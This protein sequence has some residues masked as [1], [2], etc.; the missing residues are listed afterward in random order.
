[1]TTFRPGNPRTIRFALPLAFFVSYLFASIDFL[2]I[3]SYLLTTIPLHEMG[4]AMMAWMGG[5]WAIPLG[6]IVPTAGMTLIAYSR[7]SVFIFFYYSLLVYGIYYFHRK[8]Y[9]F[10]LNMLVLIFFISGF[11]T[12]RIDE[13]RLASYI[14]LAGI[15]G[16]IFLSTFLIISF[17]YNL[18]TRFRWDFWRFPV[19]FFGACG[20]TNT[21]LQWYR[22]KNNLQALPM[23]SAVSGE[24]ARDMSGDLNQ[25][26]LAGWSPAQIIVIY[27]SFIKICIV[28]IVGYYVIGLFKGQPQTN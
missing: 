24:G 20:F 18:T 16:E 7:S 15:M 8:Q 13:L 1:M 12:F 4:H 3:L 10:H 19:L 5:R 2:R 23:G 9:S 11:L 25:L 6:A 21:A 28:V 27:W 14:S 22:I 17:Y 26:I